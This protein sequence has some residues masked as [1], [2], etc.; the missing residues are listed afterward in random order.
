VLEEAH[1]ELSSEESKLFP[2]LVAHTECMSG[3]SSCNTV[4]TL[5]TGGQKFV[6]ANHV[7]GG[8]FN[9]PLHMAGKESAHPRVACIP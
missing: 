4:H 1:E 7:F 8:P 6:F 3:G 9:I 5:S 2:F